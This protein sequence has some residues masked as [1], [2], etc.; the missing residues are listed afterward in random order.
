MVSRGRV[1]TFLPRHRWAFL[2][3]LA[4][5]VGG[6]SPPL[7]KFPLREPLWR[8]DD[9]HPFADE[10]E[11]Y[12][13]PFGWDATD[14]TLFHPVSRF[15]AVSP[16]GAA[17]NV[18][19]LDEVPDSSWFENRL[20]RFPLTPE[21]VARGAC[22]SEPL[23]PAGPWT[24]T[25]AKPNGANPGFIIQA[26][27]GRRYLLKF[28]GT[29]Q[30]PRATSADVIV[31]KLYH[32]AGFHTPCNEIVFFHRSVLRIDPGAT[33]EDETGRKEPLTDHHLDRVFAKAVR[34]PDG[35]WRASAS[36]FLAGKPLGPWRYQGTRR[37]D[38]NDVIPHQ[39][40][41]ELRGAK[42]L[43]AWTNHFDAREQNTMDA[44]IE[45]GGAKGYVR[46]YYL[47]FGDCLG[48]IWEP[49]QWGRRLGHSYYF[50]VQH[51]AGDFLTLGAITRPWDRARFGASGPVFGYYRVADFVPDTYHPGYPNPAFSRMREGDAAW[52]T[53]IISRFSR[54]H[55][56]AAIATG[57]MDS[58][59]LEAELLR[60]LE[61]RRQIILRRYLSRVSPLSD[62]TLLARARP[63]LCLRD[64]AVESGVVDRK[65]RR[66]GAWGWLE[67]TARISLGGFVDRGGIGV[68]VPLPDVAPD[69]AK[70]QSSYLLIDIYT[71]APDHA[72]AFPRG[73]GGLIR[74]GP[75]PVRVH[76]HQL[77]R[78]PYRI[79]G[80]ERPDPGETHER[81]PRRQFT[82]VG[83]K[84]L[85][86]R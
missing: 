49:P 71:D 48:S 1:K 20:G 18:N 75:G 52:M 41:R 7:R 47:D 59:F 85:L 50:D 35:R 76:L 23:D 19:A 72:E 67:G 13:S 58:P 26:S 44:W 61:A 62:A 83:S 2:L 31:S 17:V 3:S 42:V 54:E 22:D 37:D 6:C 4:G 84:S 39:D 8:D 64:M 30:G 46:H 81:G 38:P 77:G 60:L 11:E 40:R 28:D 15:F 34:L 45:T 70:E 10:P 68:C 74:H 63:E 36:L 78:G 53:R 14:Q 24:V 79:V 21:Q 69:A 25:G 82:P 56:A 9:Q 55:L 33:G 73:S 65:T 32:A 86:P 66:Y 29:A 80:L 51:V 43:A 16:P 57:R 12:Y 5:L 27:D